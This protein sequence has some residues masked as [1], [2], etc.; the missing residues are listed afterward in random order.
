MKPVKHAPA[1]ARNLAEKWPIDMGMDMKE[2]V[3][4][5]DDATRTFS[6]AIDE[7]SMPAKNVVGTIR[8]DDHGDGTSFVSWS[9]K[10]VLEPESAEQFAPMVQSMYESGLASLESFHL[11][12]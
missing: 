9:A 10:L 3:I 8:V 1:S 12:P 5:R 2:R 4:L 6:Y 11:K 7:H